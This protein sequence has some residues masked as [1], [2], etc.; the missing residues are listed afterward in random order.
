MTQ[1]N[2]ILF[3]ASDRADEP[4]YLFQLALRT[5][6]D[7][8]QTIEEIHDLMVPLWTSKE[9]DQNTQDLSRFRSRFTEKRIISMW[10]S[11]EILFGAYTKLFPVC[12]IFKHVDGTVVESLRM[13]SF[14]ATSRA[15]D[16]IQRLIEWLDLS[17]FKI[18]QNVWQSTV[19]ELHKALQTL[20]ETFGQE[21]QKMDRNLTMFRQTYS[22]CILV[23]KLL[24]IFMRKLTRADNKEL[25][26]MP[27]NQHVA[28]LKATS[29]FSKG[30]SSLL[31]D[32]TSIL[33]NPG[34]R[35]APAGPVAGTV[36]QAMKVLSQY[37]DLQEGSQRVLD[38]RGF[39]DWSA[40][41][42]TLFNMAV[43]RFH[44]SHQIA[45]VEWS[46]A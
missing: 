8:E 16:N 3:C 9:E 23:L 17:D 27:P 26:Q 36:T 40:H 21:I 42:N 13:R 33:T 12:G 7:A 11:I 28:L 44:T 15:R 45:F 46:N 41:W 38:R 14:K 32:M 43:K 6:L 18:L 1:L 2:D 5:L 37:F 39:R 4:S 19:N 29:T 35:I 34:F 24:T 31:A 20:P 22:D 10:K 30:L 25:A